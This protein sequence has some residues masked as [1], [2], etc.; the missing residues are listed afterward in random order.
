MSGAETSTVAEGRAVPPPCS[1]DQAGRG[2][3]ALFI[4]LTA[5]LLV[6]AV[7]GLAHFYHFAAHGQLYRPGELG[8]V[9][10]VQ[11]QIAGQG[12][13]HPYLGITS[14]WPHH[15]LNNIPPLL[16]NKKTL[17]AG[18]FGGSVAQQV[19]LEFQARLASFLRE[20]GIDM[21]PIVVELAQGG[22]KQ[23]Q[24]VHALAYML[25]HGGEFDLVVNLD[26]HNDISVPHYNVRRGVFPS[27]PHLWDKR[28]GATAADKSLL[29]RVALLKRDRQRLKTLSESVLGL[30]ATVGNLVKRR[31]DYLETEILRTNKA[32]L[33]QIGYY[34]VESHGPRWGWYRRGYEADVEQDVRN[35]A[36]DIWYQSSLLMATLSAAAGADYFHFLQPSQYIAG[37]K[38]L[39][40][41]EMSTAYLP[42]WSEKNYAAT[43]PMLAQRG[44]ALQE[45]GVRFFDLTQTFADVAE[46]VYVDTCCHVN[47]RG[48]ELLAARMLDAVK[49]AVLRRAADLAGSRKSILDAARR[50]EYA[51]LLVAEDHY[52]IYLRDGKWLVYRRQSCAEE[53]MQALF[54][55]HAVPVDP[56]MLPEERTAAGYDNLDFGFAEAGTFMSDGS[57]VAQGWLPAYD[58]SRIRTGQYDASGRLWGVEFEMP[59]LPELPGIHIERTS[60]HGPS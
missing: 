14:D 41:E 38:V 13:A 42:G 28:V 27:F 47:R 20:E 52:D 7:E 51:E 19:R 44:K 60:D 43:Y 48:N 40:A 23:P 58:I 3:K 22:G 39:T 59:K 35:L 53:D 50:P 57:C 6:L 45:A 25:A 5:V 1:A 24:Q 26:G 17:V 55:L 21:L 11:E 31:F 54:F 30:S 36:V 46:T 49:P 16:E 4:G 33:G 9:S 29:G 18:I 2:K 12:V 56:L 15:P 32:L 10:D 34:D 8:V 37:A